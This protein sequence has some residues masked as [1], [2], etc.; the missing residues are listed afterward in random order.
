VKAEYPLKRFEKKTSEG[1]IGQDKSKTRLSLLFSFIIW[2][3]ASPQ[4]FTLYFCSPFTSVLSSYSF[5]V[6]GFGAQL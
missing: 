6:S 4:K 3:L 2:L 1:G 5:N